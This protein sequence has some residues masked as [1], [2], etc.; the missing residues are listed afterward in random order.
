[1]AVF[2]EIF[3]A[4]DAITCRLLLQKGRKIAGN[5]LAAGTCILM[6][7][8][9]KGRYIRNITA[10]NKEGYTWNKSVLLLYSIDWYFLSPTMVM[11]YAFIVILD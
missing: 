8:V 2:P 11:A 1:V 10:V 3:T 5:I 9:S 7:I 6:L 4:D